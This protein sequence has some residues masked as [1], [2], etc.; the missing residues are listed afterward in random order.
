MNKLALAQE[1]KRLADEAASYSASRGGLEE[2][3]RCRRAIEA[4]ADELIALLKEEETH[5]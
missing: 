4:R 2:R 1:I 3:E 5:A